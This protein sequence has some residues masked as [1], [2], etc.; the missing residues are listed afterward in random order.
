MKIV[1]IEFEVDTEVNSAALE[2]KIMADIKRIYY[3][4]VKVEVRVYKK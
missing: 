3:E 2:A 4:A 1:T